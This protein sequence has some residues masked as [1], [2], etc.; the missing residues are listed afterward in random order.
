MHKIVLFLA[1]TFP[2]MIQTSCAQVMW[3]HRFLN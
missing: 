2:P 1:V 3:L